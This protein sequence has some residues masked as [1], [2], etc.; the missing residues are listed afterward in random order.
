MNGAQAAQAAWGTGAVLPTSLGPIL[1]AATGKGVCC[2]AFGEGG[3]GTQG[4]LFPKAETGPGQ[5]KISRDLIRPPRIAGGGRNS[6]GR[7]IA[8]H[9]ISRCQKAPAYPATV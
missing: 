1:V 7:A 8:A 3:A 4:A 5:A 9:T 2:L 6:R